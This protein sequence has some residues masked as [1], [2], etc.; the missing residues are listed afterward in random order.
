MKYI[1]FSL[2]LFAILSCNDRHTKIISGLEGE[3]L[4][5][6]NMLLPDS[7]TYL[8]SENIPGGEPFVLFYFSPHCPYCRAMT[9]DLKDEMKTV[10]DIR[11]YFI[12]QSPL[13][14]I[15]KYDQDYGLSKYNN[16]TLAQVTDTSFSK[17]YQ[18]QG[19]PY[20]AVYNSKKQL[21]EVLIGICD[22]DVI[23]NIAFTK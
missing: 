16:I 20:L 9:K 4:P 22:I 17:Y 6:F 23:K 19:V 21:K 8:N 7:T 14:Q 12:A 18:I 13:N 2:L 5:S 3:P 11:F 1:S 10:K 15:R